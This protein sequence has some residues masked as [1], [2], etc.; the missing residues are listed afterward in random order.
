M[1]IHAALHS[2]HGAERVCGAKGKPDQA[3]E[4][5]HSSVDSLKR[6]LRSLR[7]QMLR[8]SLCTFRCQCWRNSMRGDANGGSIALRPKAAL[9]YSM[10][11]ACGTVA[12]MSD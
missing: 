4:G 8:A 5:H 3:R 1:Q 9:P 2:Q 12:T 7:I 6:S 10:P 11:S